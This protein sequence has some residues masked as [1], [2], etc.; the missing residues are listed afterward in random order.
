MIAYYLM[1][2]MFSKA[3]HPVGHEL[4]LSSFCLLAATSPDGADSYDHYVGSF[5]GHPG[6]T[7]N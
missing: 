4:T 1:N 5:A 2:I 6:K 7:V 3:I